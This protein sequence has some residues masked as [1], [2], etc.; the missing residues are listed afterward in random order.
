MP[1]FGKFTARGGSEVE[2]SLTTLLTKM[3]RAFEE[4][5]PRESYRSVILIGGYGRG[6]GGVQVID[7]SERP[8]NN[9]DFMVITRPGFATDLYPRMRECVA[10]FAQDAGLGIDISFI[11]EQRLV[12]SPCLVMWYDMRF[13]HKTVIGDDLFLRGLDQFSKEKI[14]P[15]DVLRLMVNRGTLLVI[16]DA[17][18][19]KQA[20]QESDRKLIIKHVMKALIGFGDAY[21]FSRGEYD[22][23]YAEKQQR[24][25]SLA[26]APSELKR[27]YE[28]ALEFR[29]SPNYERYADRDLQEWMTEL[30]GLL[31]EPY[32]DFERF[33]LGKPSLD[34]SGYLP[35][36]LACEFGK[37]LKSPRGL[38]KSLVYALRTRGIPG[39]SGL[40]TRLAARCVGDRILMPLIFPAVYFDV[41]DGAYEQ[42]AQRYLKA[43]TN[44]SRSR[45]NAYLRKW[46]EIGDSNFQN[47][48]D[49]ND[50]PLHDD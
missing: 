38:A 34:W 10:Q 26:D 24:M 22:W 42:A 45:R 43:S 41:D 4:I 13:G 19:G 15:F 47:V 31:R 23:S 25:Q 3:G 16:N 33:R 48:I 29:F 35:A 46:G 6:E 11:E 27:L 2:A 32:L 20:L 30:R 21:L 1:D 44:K 9:L 37:A 12:Q 40:R 28:E 36:A 18:L 8:H 39:V 49:A 14:E 5:L 17:V 50:I 7:G